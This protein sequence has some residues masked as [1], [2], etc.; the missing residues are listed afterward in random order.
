MERSNNCHNFRYY[1]L[2][3]VHTTKKMLNPIL[4]PLFFAVLVF[5]IFMMR[6]MIQKSNGWIDL[7][8]KYESKKKPK[9]T[10]G[11]NLK[12]QN[13]NFGGDD[14]SGLLKF[15]DTFEGL[16]ITPVWFVRKSEHNILIPWN[17]F[18]EYRERKVFFRKKVRLI[19]G[20]P[21]VSFIDFSEKDFKKIK[22]RIS[23]NLN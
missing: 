2:F 8:S 22:K 11:K 18:I 17:E 7:A 23:N 1:C 13:C 3:L 9:E 15:Y 21:F 19:I 16:L 4:I 10:N 20:N 12:I 6:I 5:I 14:I